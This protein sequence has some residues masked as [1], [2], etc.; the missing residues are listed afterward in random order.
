MWSVDHLIWE[1]QRGCLLPVPTETHTF[2]G[3]Q[4][5]SI[6]LFCPEQLEASPEEF[7]SEVENFYATE[8]WE[9]SEEAKGA[10]NQPDQLVDRIANVTDMAS[11]SV[12]K[13]WQVWVKSLGKHASL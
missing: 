10:A 8:K 2:Q 5:L 1:H 9:S 11:I 12:Y 7:E 6:N 4:I 3:N 13:N